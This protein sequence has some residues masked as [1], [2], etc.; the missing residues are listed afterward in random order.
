[1]FKTCPRLGFTLALLDN[2][3]HNYTL[4]NEEDINQTKT[5]TR[6][7]LRGVHVVYETPLKRLER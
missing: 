2:L 6:V 4:V 5:R 3:E 7:F 1:M